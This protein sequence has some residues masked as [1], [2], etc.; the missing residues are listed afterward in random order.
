MASDPHTDEHILPEAP[1]GEG[2]LLLGLAE[3]C[4]PEDSLVWSLMERAE[5]LLRS[6]AEHSREAGTLTALKLRSLSS[7]LQ[8]L[9]RQSLH[10]VLLEGRLTGPAGRS[11]AL[12]C[13]RLAPRGGCRPPRILAARRGAGAAGLRSVDDEALPAGSLELPGAARP[14]DP[15]AS[16]GKQEMATPGREYP[17]WLAESSPPGGIDHC[18]IGLPARGDLAWILPEMGVWFPETVQRLAGLLWDIW[19]DRA[20]R[21]SRGS[22]RGGVP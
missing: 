22:D 5:A 2:L 21:P 14:Q 10:T 17:D 13:H 7:H 3:V 20:G 19:T 18:R 11:P 6:R 15:Q 1:P 12:L 8:P 9:I 4:A 16:D